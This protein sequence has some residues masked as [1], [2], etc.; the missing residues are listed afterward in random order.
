MRK[1][2]LIF[3]AALMMAAACTKPEEKKDPII[4][5]PDDDKPEDKGKTPII[6]EVVTPWTA[7]YFDIHFI[8]TTHGECT[9]LIFPD[10][11]QMLIDAAGAE[12]ETG[13]VGSTTNVGMRKRWDPG[14]YP[15]FVCSDYIEDYMHKC[16]AW[17]GNNKI[18]YVLV[19]HFHNDHYGAHLGLPNS[20][21]T[22]TYRRQSL[23]AILEDV[24]VGKLLDRGYPNY[25]YPVDMMKYYKMT[26]ASS[27]ANYV[28]AVRYLVANKGLNVEKVVAGSNSQVA[29]NYDAATYPSFKVQNIGVNGDVWTGVGTGYTSTF[30]TRDQIQAPKYPDVAN[31]D[32]C[33]EEN[34]VSAVLRFTYGQFDYWAGGDMQYDGMSSFGW[35]DIETPMAQACGVVDVM[36]ADH[37]GTA[38]TNG[39]GYNN[40]AWAMKYLQPQCWIVNSWTDG[41]PRQNTYESVTNYLKDAHV[42]ITNS[43]QEH[44]AYANS[45]RI[46]GSNGHILVRV[47]PG[48]GSYSIYTLSDSDGKMTV[49]QAAGP[50]KSK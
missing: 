46:K 38:N 45:D 33:P 4:I 42:F 7:G 41:H 26:N 39:S 25:D 29:L 44:K 50:Y 30:P 23:V 12:Q 24:E 18:D 43:P 20:R 16:M 11:T 8:N 49:K 40:K 21:F 34:H 28:T 9:F 15:K 27:V 3:A 10:G 14:C 2:A 32:R 13:T 37:H 35:K 36:K 5:N 22:N 19:T 31:G 47:K 1:T 17:T 48:G 6:G